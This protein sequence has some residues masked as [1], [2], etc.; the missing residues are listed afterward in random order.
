MKFPISSILLIDLCY[1]W[2]DVVS[3]TNPEG[4]FL[5]YDEAQKL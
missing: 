5:S 1:N 2:R 3:A 4:G